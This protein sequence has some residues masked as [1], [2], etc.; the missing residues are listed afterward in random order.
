V[1]NPFN[2]WGLI[3]QVCG[4][5]LRIAPVFA[6][7]CEHEVA[8]LVALPSGPCGRPPPAPGSTGKT[9]KQVSKM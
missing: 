3:G 1:G 2:A 5:C 8:C 7:S 9:Q 6:S 4:F